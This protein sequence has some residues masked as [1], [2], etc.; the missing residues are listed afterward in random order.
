MPFSTVFLGKTNATVT[1]V[2]RTD[3]LYC[4]IA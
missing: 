2:K 4:A 1:S 3:S